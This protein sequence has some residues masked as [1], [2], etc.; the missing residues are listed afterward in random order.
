MI[1]ELNGITHI[2]YWLFLVGYWIF[3]K[4]SKCAIY[5]AKR[6]NYYEEAES[7]GFP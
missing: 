7:Q 6:K 2:G 3:K 1:K 4:M 5:T